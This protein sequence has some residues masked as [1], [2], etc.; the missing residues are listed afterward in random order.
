[1]PIFAV[2]VNPH[3]LSQRN[4]HNGS[5]ANN[6]NNDGNGNYGWLGHQPRTSLHTAVLLV[7]SAANSWRGD[8][9]KKGGEGGLLRCHSLS[10]GFVLVALNDHNKHKNY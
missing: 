9:E 7:S 3:V 8:G 6:R 10:L 1:M 2:V 5:N 4:R